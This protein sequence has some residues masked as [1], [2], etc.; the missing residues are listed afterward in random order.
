[1]HVGDLRVDAAVPDGQTLLVL[2]DHAI[3]FL[4]ARADQDGGDDADA[5]AAHAAHVHAPGGAR[6]GHVVNGRHFRQ[7]VEGH[8]RQ[9]VAAAAL[10]HD[11][12]VLEAP[13]AGLDHRAGLVGHGHADTGAR[14]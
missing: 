2:E 5:H 6:L 8:V 14:R 7:L 12:H 13:E 9:G 1:M 4:V 3:A 10:A 11:R